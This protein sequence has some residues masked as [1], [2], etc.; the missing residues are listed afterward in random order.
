MKFISITTG[1]YLIVHGYD[2]DNRE[3]TE[4]VTVN[5]PMKKLVA[6]KRIQ[7]ISEKYV[8]VTRSHGRLFYW[9]Y[10]ESFDELRDLLL[11][12]GLLTN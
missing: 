9:E 8:L 2:A 11:A 12:Y 3:I 4:T 10:E 5:A 1:N 6:V 7:S